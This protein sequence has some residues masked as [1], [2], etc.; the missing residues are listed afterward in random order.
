MTRFGYVMT[1]YFSVLAIGGLS[2]VSMTPRLIWNATASTPV[3][4]YAVQPDRH[5]A[6]GDLLAVR[7]PERLAAFLAAGGY[8]PRGVPLLKQVAAVAGEIVCRTG[9]TITIDGITVATA[10]ERDHL[11]RPLPAW[12]GCHTLQRGELFLLNRHPDSLDGRYF[13]SIPASTVLGRARPLLT[14]ERGDGTFRWRTATR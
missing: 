4:L 3:G 13:G 8:L 5:P 12:S 2:L 6:V 7:P 14:D 11:G 1:T 9:I 10:H